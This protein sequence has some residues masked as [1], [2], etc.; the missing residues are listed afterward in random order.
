MVLRLA[1]TIVGQAALETEEVEGEVEGDEEGKGHM[2][3]IETI[4]L[5]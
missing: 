2:I 1:T 3:E 4:T 5:A